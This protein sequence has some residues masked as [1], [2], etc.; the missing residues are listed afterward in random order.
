MKWPESPNWISQQ[1]IKSGN[2]L[3]FLTDDAQEKPHHWLV[4]ITF[5][6]LVYEKD[7]SSFKDCLI[8]LIRKYVFKVDVIVWQMYIDMN[9]DLKQQNEVITRQRYKASLA[10]HWHRRLNTIGNR[11][12]HTSQYKH[13]CANF[14]HFRLA[15]L[16]VNIIIRDRLSTGVVHVL[17]ILDLETL[18][19][20]SVFCEQLSLFE[21]VFTSTYCLKTKSRKLL[22]ISCWH[23][24][25]IRSC[26]ATSVTKA[27]R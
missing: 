16:G 27:S 21:Y 4:K 3:F 2:V 1:I 5:L 25:R 12:L 14:M 8:S 22:Q 9:L 17:T 23:S 13:G 26:N 6:S 18:L 10:S 15:R 7:K 24:L 19:Y 11:V 20:V